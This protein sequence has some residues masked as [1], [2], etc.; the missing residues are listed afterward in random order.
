MS[1]T[2]PEENAKG[3]GRRPGATALWEALLSEQWPV[4][5]K[6]IESGV[7]PLD[8]RDRRDLTPLMRAVSGEKTC[9]EWHRHLRILV[10]NVK[11]KI[12]FIQTIL[13]IFR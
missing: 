3:Y 2:I 4:A 11:C 9:S 13:I 7:E 12:V 1:N 10:S 6:L 8:V 5:L